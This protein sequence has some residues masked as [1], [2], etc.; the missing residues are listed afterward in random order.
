[1]EVQHRVRVLGGHLSERTAQDRRGQRPP[2]GASA[3]R[4]RAAADGPDGDR[5]L[6]DLAPVAELEPVRGARDA[7][8]PVADARRVVLAGVVAEAELGQDV[9]GPRSFAGDREGRRAVAERPLAAELL[10]ELGAALDVRT[11]LVPGLR[12]DASVGEPVAG[13]LVALGGDCAH[14][15]RIAL[16]RHAEDEER[17]LR[18]QLVEELE[19]RRRLPLEG[20]AAPVP[21]VVGRGRGGRA[22]ASLRS[23]SRAGAWAWP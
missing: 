5:V 6:P 4:D 9:V 18:V 3:H 13:E 21:V 23:R 17:G 19:D 11:E 20:L 15:V 10:D 12:R 7:S 1:M 8:D 2:V 16:G 14:E 22:G